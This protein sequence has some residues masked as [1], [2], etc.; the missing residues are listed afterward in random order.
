VLQEL[1]QRKSRTIE[2]VALILEELE[3]EAPAAADRRAAHDINVIEGG[4]YAP[5]S[6]LARYLLQSGVGEK[7]L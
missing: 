6:G 3:A 4:D 2:Q 7:L 1:A 5:S